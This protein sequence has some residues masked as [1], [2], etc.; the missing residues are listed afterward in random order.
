MKSILPLL[1]LAVL[2]STGCSTLGVQGPRVFQDSVKEPV[3]D[4]VTEDVKQASEYLA[5]NVD[6][7]TAP[8]AKEVAV[9]LSQRVGPP[10]KSEED[11]LK[12][13]ADLRKERNDYEAEIRKLNRW[14]EKREGTDL[15]GTGLSVFGLGGGLIIVGVVAL[16]VLVPA[17]I[18]LVFQIIQIIAGTSRRVLKS[19]VEGTV[20][21][22]EEFRKKR[23]DAIEDLEDLLGRKMDRTS[24]Q[25]VQKVKK[26]QLE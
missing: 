7:E 3:R 20:D 26:R 17:L 13:I 10:E 15:E 16:C 4:L 1:L 2:F 22:V 21:A 11:Y 9:S 8:E 25:V 14:L 6:E 19:T 5:K 18:P 23:P 24:K 12:I